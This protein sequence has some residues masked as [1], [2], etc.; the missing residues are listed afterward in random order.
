MQAVL[1]LRSQWQDQDDEKNGPITP[2]FLVSEALG[3]DLA[4]VP[5]L[6][7]LCIL[8]VKMETYNAPKGPLQCKSCQLFEHTQR[9]A[10]THL[11]AW[12]VATPKHPGRVTPEGSNISAAVVEVTI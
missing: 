1:Q 4:E 8:R 10:V 2:H 11:G 5:S 7:E 12:H 9:T 3:P 6:S